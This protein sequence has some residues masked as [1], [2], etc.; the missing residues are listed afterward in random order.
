MG[1]R[2]DADTTRRRRRH[3]RR[4]RTRHGARTAALARRAAEKSPQVCWSVASKLESLELARL[5]RQYPLRGRKRHE[6]SV[7]ARAVDEWTQTLYGRGDARADRLM[8]SSAEELRRLRR[9]VDQPS[10]LGSPL[11]AQDAQEGLTAF[12]GGFFTG[13]GTFGLSDRALACMSLPARGIP[14]GR[15][16]TRSPWPSRVGPKRFVPRGWAHVAAPGRIAAVRLDSSALHRLAQVSVGVAIA[17][18][19]LLGLVLG[20]VVSVTTDVPLAPEVGLALGALVGW[21][22]RRNRV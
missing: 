21:L 10:G 15:R 6:F 18:G 19:A 9:Y 12:L 2:N 7:W 13:E 22:S 16:A 14:N 17:I 11:A 20:I 5:L 8:R 4:H 1:V 3:A